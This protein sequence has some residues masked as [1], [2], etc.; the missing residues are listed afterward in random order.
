MPT[1]P[2]LTGSAGAT[3]HGRFGCIVLA[4]KQGLSPRPPPRSLL[5]SWTPLANGEWWEVV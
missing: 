4:G 3:A 2:A 1:S 5:G